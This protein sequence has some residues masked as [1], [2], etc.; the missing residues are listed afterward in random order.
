MKKIIYLIIAVM[1]STVY[2]S[3]AQ[4]FNSSV[5]K[6]IVIVLSTKDYATAK[7]IAGEASKKL[8]KPLNLNGLKPN[9]ELGLTHSKE[10][11]ES[12]GYPCYIPRG[13]GNAENSDYISVEYSNG[14]EGFAKGYYIVVAGI[15]DPKT[16]YLNQVL[17]NAKKYY[18]DAYAKQTKVWYG[19]MH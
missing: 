6:K 17:T 10:D 12:F 13:E 5:P 8:G 3:K 16:N 9:K 11:C 4:E 18:K 15:G 1:L 7:K 19:C 2:T 14:Y